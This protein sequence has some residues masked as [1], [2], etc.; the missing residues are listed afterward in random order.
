MAFVILML[1]RVFEET[2]NPT[3]Y[4][5]LDLSERARVHFFPFP[6]C[7]TLMCVAATLFKRSGASRQSA[8][9]SL[10]VYFILSSSPSLLRYTF[11]AFDSL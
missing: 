4:K 2:M 8:K 6:A 9:E 3:R 1:V 11:F 5:A 7:F 10:C